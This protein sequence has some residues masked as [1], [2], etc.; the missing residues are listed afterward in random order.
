MISLI[1]GPPPP[2]FQWDSVR[3]YIELPK[4]LELEK[5]GGGEPVCAGFLERFTSVLIPNPETALA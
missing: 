2:G 3:R 1:C 4:N 5:C